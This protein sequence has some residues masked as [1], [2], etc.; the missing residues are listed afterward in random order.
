[1]KFPEEY[2][3]VDASFM[4]LTE[5]FE[6]SVRAAWNYQKKKLEDRFNTILLKC[7]H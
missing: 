7:Q 3:Y 4:D 2:E 5:T 6:D 1:M